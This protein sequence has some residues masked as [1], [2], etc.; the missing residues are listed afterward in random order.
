MMCQL[1]RGVTGVFGL[2]LIFVLTCVGHALVSPLAA[3][4]PAWP[5]RWLPTDSQGWTVL[6]PN[7]ESRLIYVSAD[8]DDATAR[9]YAAASVEV[10]SDPTQ[11]AGEIRAYR[12]IAAAKAQLRPEQPD[13]LLLRRGD[14]W[15]ESLGKMASGGGSEAPAV[16]CAYGPKRERPVIMPGQE[17]GMQ[18]DMKRGFHD[19]VISDLE[20]YSHTKDPQHPDFGKQPTRGGGAGFYL[21]E[22]AVGERLLFEDCCFRYGGFSFTCRGRMKDLVLRRNLVLGNYSENSHSQGCWGSQITVLLEENIFD[23]NGWL[24]QGTG[25]KQA[26]G[27]AT[28]F[29]HNTYFC[30]CHE[31]IF[32]GNMFLRASS[33][34][35]KWTANDG[36]GSTRN[37]VM[38][39]NLYV[40]G[41]IGFS[42]GGNAQGPLRFKNVQV[43]NNV[44]LDLGRGRPTLRNLGWGLDIQ[45]WDGGLVA[46]NCFLHQA[47]PDI[48]NVHAIN[49]TSGDDKGRYRGMGV[50]CR[51]VSVC[52][53]VVHGL[54]SGG[55]AVVVSHGALMENVEIRGNAVQMPG[56]PTRL[57][58]VSGE[59]GGVQF[60][61]NRY[62]SDAVPGEWFEADRRPFSPGDWATASGERDAVM[63]QQAFTDPGRCIETYMAQLGKSPTFDAFLDEVRRQSKTNWHPEFTATAVNAWVRAGFDVPTWKPAEHDDR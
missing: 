45:D 13:W 39:D 47:S 21:G 22:T 32:R 60:S 34:G 6:R 35:N 23:H 7:A 14:A 25:N 50:H 31:V 56:L 48:T 27:G 8:G 3:D 46:N 54:I 11:P 57:V 41:E 17:V 38:D 12:T 58:R 63:K 26:G 61:G 36:P 29:N 52:D 19:I 53:N 24:K 15:K 16:T 2:V 49:V 43:T 59:L 30:D 18:F 4:E 44:L 37:I 55:S 10:G 40:E 62:Y 42:I 9:P 28:I 20:I 51:N 33:I 5:A 1:G